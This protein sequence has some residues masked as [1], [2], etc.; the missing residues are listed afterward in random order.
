MINTLYHWNG[1]NKELLVSIHNFS[2]HPTFHLI[3]EI[4]SSYIGHFKWATVTIPVIALL[5]YLS[6]KI[7]KKNQVVPYCFSALKCFAVMLISLVI[8]GEIV[9]IMKEYFA[10]P[11]PFCSVEDNLIKNLAMHK[12]YKHKCFQSFPSGHTAYVTVLLASLWPIL[13][14]WF[15]LLGIAIVI[16]VGISRVVLAMHYPMDVGTGCFIALVTVVIM[17]QILAKLETKYK[18]K[19]FY[20]CQCLT[21]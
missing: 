19:A 7:K 2:Y 10:M 9:D 8:A 18:N 11:R 1:Y 5:V 20:I 21:K 16:L 6:F 15:R 13:N 4:M 17:H 3:M 12:A 14:F